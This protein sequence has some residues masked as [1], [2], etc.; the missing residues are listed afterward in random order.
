MS[1][2]YLW[3]PLPGFQTAACERWEDEVLMG[4][5]A[6]PGKTDILVMEAT[7][8]VSV[9]DYKALILRRSFP[10]LEEIIDRARKY[11]PAIQGEYR[12]GNHTWYFP[13]GAQIKFGH[14]QNPGDEYNYQ[15]KEY[16][17]IR[18]EERR[19]GKECRSRWS[20]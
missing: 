5:A 15:G 18:S 16:Q 2:E 20:P 11:Y 19:V 3:R 8:Y 10:Q 6:G 4:G 14:I 13:S 7:R 12:A 17:Y 9:S 1:S